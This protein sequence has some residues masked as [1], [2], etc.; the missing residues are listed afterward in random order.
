[1]K[2]AIEIRPTITRSPDAS[3]SDISTITP[4]PATV[5][6]PQHSAVSSAYP[7]PASTAMSVPGA[8]PTSTIPATTATAA[9]G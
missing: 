5:D 7:V 8:S 2:I 3:R 4:R 1:M 9:H 6:S